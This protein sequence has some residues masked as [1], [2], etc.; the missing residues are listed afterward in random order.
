MNYYYLLFSL[1]FCI[2]S[3]NAQSSFIAHFKCDTN[4]KVDSLLQDIIYIE[5]D[6]IEINNRLTYNWK[7]Y[8]TDW[9]NEKGL[10]EKNELHNFDVQQIHAPINRMTRYFYDDNGNILLKLIGTRQAFLGIRKFGEEYDEDYV[11]QLRN[12][13]TA[14]PTSL[15]MV[16]YDYDLEER[17]IYVN[18]KNKLSRKIQFDEN[19]NEVLSEHYR[20]GRISTNLK[21]YDSGNL[22]EQVSF[23]NENQDTATWFYTYDVE[24]RIQSLELVKNDSIIQQKL[25]EYPEEDISI[26]KSIINNE[27]SSTITLQASSENQFL[28]FSFEKA[29]RE[30]ISS[31]RFNNAKGDVIK[32][33]TFLQD[34]K[35]IR[36]TEHHIEYYE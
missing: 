6:A 17:M 23:N 30:N 15:S 25:Y 12:K 36:I 26:E 27:V 31:I 14:E 7:V 5:D 28:D 32:I 8:S 35:R 34:G 33:Y 29:L 24:N 16:T 13:M 3:M 18:Q 1:I 20:S 4:I 9:Y 11:F 19:K 2:Q 22:I 21:K 10:L